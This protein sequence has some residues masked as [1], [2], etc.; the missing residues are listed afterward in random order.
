MAI[1]GRTLLMNPDLAEIVRT[2]TYQPAWTG[3]ELQNF[4]LLLAGYA[5]AIGVKTGYTD[6]AHQTIVAAADDEGRRVIVVL[7]RSDDIYLEVPR[8]LDWAF[9]NTP[10]ACQQQVAPAG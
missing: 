3:P 5:G 7:L 6:V 4:N 2:Q 10:V 9:E 8:L 1:I